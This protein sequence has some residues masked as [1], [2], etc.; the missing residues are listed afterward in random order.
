MKEKDTIIHH[1]DMIDTKD[2]SK[3][4]ASL[5]MPP[6]YQSNGNLTCVYELEIEFHNDF[7][8]QSPKV[9]LL[10]TPIDGVNAI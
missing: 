8:Y 10:T 4:N 6:N 3:W 2:I 1:I 9:F 7:P 5:R